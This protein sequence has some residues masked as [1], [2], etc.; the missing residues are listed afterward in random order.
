MGDNDRIDTPLARDGSPHRRPWRFLV[1][2]A[3]TLLALTVLVGFFFRDWLLS[4]W[5]AEDDRINR[6]APDALR[7]YVP[8]D[9]GAVLGVD[10]RELRESPVGR[11]LA[12]SLQQLIRQG[13]S[14]L[15]WIDLL[16][17]NPLEDVD[18]LHIS[19]APGIGGE[20]LW[21]ARGRLERS[22][23]Q[24]G[25]DK[26]RETTLDHFRVWDYIDPRAKQTTLLAAVG[27]TL[28]VSETPGRVLAVLKQASAPQPLVV[29][30]DVLRQLL[31]K[32]DRRQSLWLAAS[33]KSLGSSAEIDDPVLKLVLRQLLA[34]AESV[35]GGI[36]CT[37]DIRL[38]FHFRAATEDRAKRLEAELQ[39]LCEAAPGAGLL[40]G[41]NKALLPL[42]RLLG[43]GQTRRDG[44]EV[45]LSC[46][47]AAD[48]LES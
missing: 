43:S 38:E 13:G 15:R 28:V 29:R 48:Q 17:L 31:T 9:S 44:N 2:F 5:R 27:D 4:R 20:P 21:L 36:T 12:P 34:H 19:F 47:L 26:I 25:Q 24:I 37:E 7:D 32:V 46:R 8:E 11:R 23:I 45:R 35:H 22:R 40:L 42:L 18:S 1:L 33:L 41:R 10:V 16:G 30:D 6:F 14:R 3:V 39:R